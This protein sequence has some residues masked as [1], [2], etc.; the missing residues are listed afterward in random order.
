MVKQFKAGAVALAVV[1]FNAVFLLVCPGVN[2][3]Q[4][5]AGEL[6]R[7][8]AELAS[9]VAAHVQG[10]GVNLGPVYYRDSRIPVQLGQVLNPELERELLNRGVRVSLAPQDEF[11]LVQEWERILSPKFND[12]ASKKIGH[13]QEADAIGL[14]KIS[15]FG[16]DFRLNLRFIDLKTGHTLSS[17]SSS[18]KQ[19]QLPPAQLEPINPMI[20]VTGEANIERQCD[21]ELKAAGQ[22][23][24][25]E[26]CRRAYIVAQSDAR[27]KIAQTAWVAL[28]YHTQMDRGVLEKEVTETQI[29]TK[30]RTESFTP[31]GYEACVDDASLHW[32]RLEARG[33]VRD[34]FGLIESRY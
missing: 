10:K 25:R 19:S 9:Q 5:Q 23:N 17:G 4:A 24:R 13:L 27:A 34:L 33:Q 20:T 8:S 21:D 3:S 22:C 14:I 18:L 28:S 16:E 29:K 7:V 32:V 12:Q 1:V 2:P 31:Q 15:Q 6:E 30:V 11:R 26:L